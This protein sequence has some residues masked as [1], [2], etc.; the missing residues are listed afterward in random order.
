MFK[1]IRNVIP[2]VKLF[3]TTTVQEEFLFPKCCC[4]KSTEVRKTGCVSLLAAVNVHFYLVWQRNLR[5]NSFLVVRIPAHQASSWMRTAELLQCS[6]RKRTAEQENEDK[7]ISL[8]TG[9]KCDEHNVKETTGSWEAPDRQRRMWLIKEV[10][11][12]LR[13]KSFHLMLF[14]L[15]LCFLPGL[16]APHYETQLGGQWSISHHTVVSSSDSSKKNL[17]GLFQILTITSVWG[18]P[19]KNFLFSRHQPEYQNSCKYINV[20]L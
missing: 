12:E 6:E 19:W 3:L 9:D 10:L 2:R 5:G 18:V 11:R 15:L 14:K 17:K 16:Q 20:H 4:S 8:K 7:T 13:G 1:R